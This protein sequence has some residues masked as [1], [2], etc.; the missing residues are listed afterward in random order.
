MIREFNID[1]AENYLQLLYVLGPELSKIIQDTLD[2]VRNFS[3]R[4][5]NGIH[6]STSFTLMDNFN[7]MVNAK[8]SWPIRL[9]N[10]S[11]LFEGVQFGLSSTNF[12]NSEYNDVKV[13][14][15]SGHS[16]LQLSFY[17]SIEPISILKDLS[18]S[19]YTQEKCFPGGDNRI[20]SQD[21]TSFCQSDY[22]KTFFSHGASTFLFISLHLDNMYF[23]VLPLKSI[24]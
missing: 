16:K 7:S 15:F 14:I 11:V 2:M 9:A 19:F 6:S 21:T 10:V 18:S 23:M 4:W 3:N 5:S 20:F 8:D 22:S 12:D 17:P 13:R 24:L 1:N